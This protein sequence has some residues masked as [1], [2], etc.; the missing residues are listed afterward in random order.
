MTLIRTMGVVVALGVWGLALPVGRA[1]TASAA[2]AAIPGFTHVKTLDGIEEYT[3]DSNGLDV[4][5][6]PDHTAPVVSFNVTYRVGSRNE[7][8]GTTGA[9]HILEHLMFKGSTAF[10]DPKGNSIKQYL[11]RVGGGYNAETS[12]DYTKYY[13]T[14]GVEGLDG[15][16][17]IEA[18]RM[19]G[20]W[21]READRQS[22][23]TVVRNEFER[24]N[25]SP[26]YVLYGEVT[27]AAYQALPYHHSTIGWKS[28]IEC[29]PINKLKAF[30]DTYYWPN[31]ATV[32]FVGDIDLGKA[33]ALVNKYYGGYKRS[34][35]A[36]PALYTEEPDQTGAR[37]VIV[38]RPGELGSVMIV[39]K[40]PNA[41]HADHAALAV[42]DGILGAGKN[43]RLYGALVDKG[44]ALDAN[45]STDGR[46]DLSLHAMSASLAP[47]VTHATVEAAL[48]AEVEKVKVTGVTAEEV[49]RVQRQ[50]LADQSYKRDGTSGIASELSA[51]I[52][53]GDWTLYESFP[54]RIAMVTPADVQRVA[55]AYLNEDQSTTGWFVPVAAK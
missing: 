10:N 2:G 40:V 24:D 22:E 27:A 8:T 7:V 41:L 37:R 34:P 39:H 54:E 48:L 4:L 6:V 5:V 35:T 32:T 55:Q 23:M 19:R 50:T 51:W 45:T 21:L 26:D 14:V 53:V 17:A 29:V 28:D 13:A 11:E 33:L 3:L 1:R 47:G 15:Y 18:D 42:L 36:I 12:L 46:H 9:T 30:Y 16:V 43:S 44:L 52:A 20:L 49:A 31:N 25:N 38:K